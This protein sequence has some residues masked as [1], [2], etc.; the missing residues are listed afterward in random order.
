MYFKKPGKGFSFKQLWR[1]KKFSA[2][3][4]HV[5]D[6]LYPLQKMSLVHELK[7]VPKNIRETL[8]RLNALRNALAHSFFPENRKAYKAAKAV[9]YKQHDIF[10]AEGFDTFQSDAREL[11][12]YLFKR[13][14]GFSPNI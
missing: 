10:S 9:L 7:P 3:A 5:L 14:F 12:D 4:Y 8:N 13:A 6:N 1:T 11:I 2:F